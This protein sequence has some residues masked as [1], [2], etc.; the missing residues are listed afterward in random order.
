MF[1]ISRLI[2][3]SGFNPPLFCHPNSD[4]IKSPLSFSY[5]WNIIV[6]H[7]GVLRVQKLL[8]TALVSLNFGCPR[9]KT[10]FRPFSYYSFSPVPPRSSRYAIAKGL[11]EAPTRT[12]QTFCAQV[13]FF[14]PVSAILIS[15][16]ICKCQTSLWNFKGKFFCGCRNIVCIYVCIYIYIYIY[17]Y[18]GK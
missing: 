11:Y 14:K 10:L 17:I 5:L 8:Q 12:T 16:Q 2:S 6:W 18:T 3:G 4:F 13:L 15:G 1:L 7:F 9:N